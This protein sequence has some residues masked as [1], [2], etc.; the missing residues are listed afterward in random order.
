MAIGLIGVIVPVVPG[1]LL[2]AVMAVVW[3]VAEGTATAVVVAAVMVAVLAAGTFLK[4]R[5]P[6]R[7][8]AA[9]GVSSLTWVLVGVGGIVGFVVIPVIGALAGVVA[10]AYLG[11]RMRFGSHSKAWASTKRV[12][13]G[14]GK[15]MA[16][17]F[18]AGTVAIVVWVVAVFAT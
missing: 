3:A 18:A 16:F 12:I 2:I 1:L 5:I 7:E 14:I 8:L 4:Y 13:A 9:Q 6:G 11:E 15:G 17:E 10:G